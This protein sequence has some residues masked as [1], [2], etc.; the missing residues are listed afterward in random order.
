M[1]EMIA[2]GS[3]RQSTHEPEVGASHDGKLSFT[4]SIAVLVEAGT[5]GSLSRKPTG[6]SSS[7]IGCLADCI[8]FL[9]VACAVIH[10]L[11]GWTIL[12]SAFEARRFQVK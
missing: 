5:V 11:F 9:M 4:Y 1:K 12:P 7:R 6:H 2:A 8:Q 10:L 3:V